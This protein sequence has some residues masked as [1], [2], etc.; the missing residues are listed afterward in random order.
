VPFAATAADCP[1]QVPKETKPDYNSKLSKK[2]YIYFCL[3]FSD[4]K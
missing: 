1:A 3:N 4:Q 2:N